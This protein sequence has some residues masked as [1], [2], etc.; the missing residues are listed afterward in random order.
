MVYLKKYTVHGSSL[1]AAAGLSHIWIFFEG[2]FYGL[3]DE[4]YPWGF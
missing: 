1:M 3:C 2:G 4:R